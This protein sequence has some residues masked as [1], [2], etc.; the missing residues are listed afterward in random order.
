M[1]M[2]NTPAE[3]EA[4]DEEHHRRWL[5]SHHNPGFEG[6]FEFDMTLEV[7][8]QRITRRVRAVFRHTPGWEYYDLNNQAL[9]VG[10]ESTAYSLELQAVPEEFHEDGTWTEGKP[11]WMAT[12]D[13]IK[14]G[15]LSLDVRDEIIQGIDKQCR[16]ED[17]E[18][19]RAAGIGS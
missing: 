4:A 8:G 5:Y 12:E 9:F 3:R 1:A 16:A 17:A 11:E 13:L 15:V 18:R 19:R 14:G 2:P 10:A 7:L 6:T